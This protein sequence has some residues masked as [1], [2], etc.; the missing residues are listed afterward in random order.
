MKLLLDEPVDR[1]IAACFP[2]KFEIKTV[3]EMGWS[4]TKNG[5][6]LEIAADAGF[7]ALITV[8]K[9]M[10]YQ[11]NL[12]KL[13]IAIIVLSTPRSSIAYLKPVIPDVISA[14][15]DNPMRKFVKIPEE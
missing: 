1:G 10:E 6:L 4:G 5:E 8:D 2:D 13:P 11:Q 15:E 14:L 3:G 12:D 7:K 9:N